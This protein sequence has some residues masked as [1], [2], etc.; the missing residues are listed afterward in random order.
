MTDVSRTQTA[1]RSLPRPVTVRPRRF[2]AALIE[3]AV[4]PV[5]CLTMTV[6]VYGLTYCWMLQR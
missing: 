5:L 3:A 6:A 4:V 1:Y 2:F